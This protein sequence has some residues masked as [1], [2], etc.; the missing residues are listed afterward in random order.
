MKTNILIPGAALAIGLGVGFGVGKSGSEVDPD[1]AA[2]QEAIQRRTSDRSGNGGAGA[3]ARDRKVRSIDEIYQ[4]PGQSNRIQALLDFYGNLSP[5][6]FSSEAEKL[7]ALPF[8]ERILASVL[9]F[10]KWAEVDPT[11]AMAF[12]DTMGFTGAFVRPTVLQGWASTDP[13]N[14]AKYYTENP[15]QFAM[16]N[17]MGGGRGGRGMGGLGAGEIIAGEWAKQDPSA[18]MDWAASL[19]SGSAGAMA[20]VVSQVAKTDP[21]KAAEMVSGMDASA[22]KGAYESIA[23]QWGS[24]NFAEASAWA[25]GLPEDQRSAAMSAAIEGL[26][27]TSPELAAGEIAKMTDA[28]ARRDAIPTVAKNYARTDARGSMNWLNS[29][30]DN[31]AKRDAMRE[32]MPIWAASDNAAA[33]E[34]IKGQTSPDVKDRAAETYIWSNR[35]SSPSELADVAGMISDDGNRTRATGI[36]AAR[37]MQE[38]KEGAT[39]FINGSDA[40]NDDMKERL[41]SGQSMW[42]GRGR[43]SR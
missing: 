4:K 40:I 23:K 17:M 26:A 41:L 25:S 39:E 27:Q 32:V 9:L 3:S 15:A 7:D 5:D 8:N 19:K 37:W 2:A 28:D 31:D 34:F 38:D 30:D 12:T 1:L 22:Q 6:Q 13:V 20:S 36:V 10:G 16:M 43:G 14:A 33:L 21:A 24:K 35:T 11:A 18:A 42:G 29:L